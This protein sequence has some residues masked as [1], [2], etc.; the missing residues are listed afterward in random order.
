M[1]LMFRLPIFFYDMTH[2]QYLIELRRILFINII[3]EII[4]VILFSTQYLAVLIIL[5]LRLYILVLLN[6]SF[7]NSLLL[8]KQN[9]DKKTRNRNI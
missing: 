3:I 5:V 8:V 1:L 9:M 7:I 4:S 6:V 2:H